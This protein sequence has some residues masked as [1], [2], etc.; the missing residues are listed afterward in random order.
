MREGQ[1]AKGHYLWEQCPAPG[2]PLALEDLPDL[3]KTLGHGHS[4]EAPS[5][6]EL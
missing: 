6:V 3:G 5:G 2:S 1:A 4:I